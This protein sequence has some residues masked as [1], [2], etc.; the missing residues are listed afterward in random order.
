MNNLSE[1]WFYAKQKYR[2][3]PFNFD[4]YTN[5][6]NKFDKCTR[7]PKVYIACGVEGKNAQ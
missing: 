5:Q 3:G 1:I 4:K 7:Q 2:F 6:S